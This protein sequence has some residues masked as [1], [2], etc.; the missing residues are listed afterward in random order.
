M[1]R[2]VVSVDLGQQADPSSV[3]V[4]EVSTRQDCVNDQYAERPGELAS[5]VTADWF[6]TGADGG[7]MYPWDAVRV[8]VRHLE[9]LP[10]KL[11]Y[12]L[13]VEHVVALMRRPPLLGASLVIDATGCGRPVLNMF[14]RRLRV[15]GVTITAGDRELRDP[16]SYW[17]WRVA[18]SL[19]VSHMQAALHGGTLRF[20]KGLPDARALVEELSDFR[21]TIGESG[22]TAFSARS[23]A[24]DDLVMAV[25]V[26]CWW[27]H[28]EHGA[29]VTGAYSV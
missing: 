29:T 9:R 28:R 5:L 18:K 16:D 20:A 2:F 8:D 17:D 27:A 24:H 6:R 25:A 26:G 21:A 3:A 15:T 12:T 14:R 22:Y 7:V 13:Q 1:S 11:D 19:L 23:G 4:L 10:L